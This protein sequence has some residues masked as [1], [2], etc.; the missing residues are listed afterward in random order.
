MVSKGNMD[1]VFIQPGRIM[2]TFLLVV[3]LSGVLPASSS[4]NPDV[5]SALPADTRILQ[6]SLADFDG[7][8]REELAILYTTA[9]ETRLTLFREDSGRWSRWWDDNGTI[10][11]QGG[12]TPQSMETVDTNGDG[13]SEMVI[14]YLTEQNAAMT[15]RIL[16][17][18]DRYPANPVF[19]VILEDMTAPPGYPVLGMEGQ[20]H[21]VTFMRM[22][23]S[24]G[25]GYRRVYCWNGEVF[26]KCKEIVWEKP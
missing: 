13:K 2:I 22:V 3:V 20:A 11:G 9:D 21:S 14:Y 15:A 18:D 6:Y 8:T 4:A 23:S 24:E 12:K 25:N 5:Y 10:N 26:E 1:C 17:L 7:D 16:T 19:N